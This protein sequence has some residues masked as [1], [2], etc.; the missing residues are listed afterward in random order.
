MSSFGWVHK[1]GF[2]L[3]N[4]QASR[5]G[6][7][8]LKMG[9]VDLGDSWVHLGIMGDIYDFWIWSPLWSLR[10]YYGLVD[11][12]EGIFDEVLGSSW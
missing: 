10:I 5:G 6:W 9:G 11:N 12:F 4:F 1:D 8:C 2:V 7:I 3:M